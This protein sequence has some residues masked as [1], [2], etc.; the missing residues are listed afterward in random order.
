MKADS[1]DNMELSTG[2]DYEEEQSYVWKKIL[3]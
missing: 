3:R 1:E 2:V